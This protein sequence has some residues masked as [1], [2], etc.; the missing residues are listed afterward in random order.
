MDAL[1]E[2]EI[3]LLLNQH[4]GRETGPVTST[5]RSLY[6]SLLKNILLGKENGAFFE[7][8]NHEKNFDFKRRAIFEQNSS[9]SSRSTPPSYKRQ[10]QI[11][12]QSNF[13][14]KSLIIGF[15]LVLVTLYLMH[16][17]LN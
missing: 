8:D 5:T 4:F 12:P 17:W 6:C 2:H 14:T 7:E 11:K 10:Q 3:F 1:S 13:F 15:I 16:V 9:L